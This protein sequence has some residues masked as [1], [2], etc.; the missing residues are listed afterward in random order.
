[1]KEYAK[2]LAEFVADFDEREIPVAAIARSRQSML[3]GIAAALSACTAEPVEI[4]V[5][6]LVKTGA[7][8]E[9]VLIGRSERF[10][11]LNAVMVNG[12]MGHYNDYDDTHLET[13]YH[14]NPMNVAAALGLGA[15]RHLS[16][17]HAITS[18]ALGMEASIRLGQ[19]LG[20]VHYESGWH[21]TGTLGTAGAALTSSRM[22]GL[23]ML[24][25]NYALGLA[26]TQASGLR[27]L[28]FGSMAKGFNSAKAA[29]NGLLAA[30]L[31]EQSFTAAENSIE[32]FRG[33]ASAASS[34]AGTERVLDG[35]V[36][37]LL[38]H[39]AVDLERI[40]DGLGSRWEVEAIGFKPY[41]SGVAT[42]AT[43]DAVL[44][45]RAQLGLDPDDAPAHATQV[46]RTIKSLTLTIPA[47]SLLL[48]R[49]REIDTPLEAKFSMY[50]VAAIV[51]TRG[52]A[53]PGE[54]NEAAL[55]D[56]TIIHLRNLMEL[57]G[58]ADA[59]QGSGALHAELT[60]GR[61]ININIDH[62]LGTKEQPLDD[63]ALDRKLVDSATGLFASAKIEQL[64]KALHQF[65]TIEDL[66]TL[67]DLVAR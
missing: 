11:L 6:V 33:Y 53:G 45:L 27:G 7:S 35:T 4:L 30:L 15:N 63:L 22:L 28:M 2:I 14:T 58:D 19:A 39:E 67:M 41:A 3:N 38:D 51:L 43:I 40:T 36:R 47:R 62:A 5:N 64:T 59:P 46:L 25:T 23:D 44:E 42:H 66:A 8:G 26:L 18:L 57:E 32:G 13:T 60:D 10:D 20:R 16:G 9:S 54:Y 52:H 50:N 31:A 29:Y 24:H 37:V 55:V 12:Y 65:A 61:E 1:M 21:T 49:Q 34:P 56:P 48:P 17:Q